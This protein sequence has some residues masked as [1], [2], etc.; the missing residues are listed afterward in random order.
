MPPRNTYLSQREFFENL[1]IDKHQIFIRS[2]EDDNW[3]HLEQVVSDAI[4]V[5]ERLPDEIEVS[6][7][8]P[9]SVKYK[10]RIDW[11]K[12]RK[13]LLV[14]YA[15]PSKTTYKTLRHDCAKRNGRR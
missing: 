9:I 7:F 11:K 12:I 4:S 1:N 3:H 14:L 6:N 2:Y 13:E 15:K 5:E 10:V 8:K